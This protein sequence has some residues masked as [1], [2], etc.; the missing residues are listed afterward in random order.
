MEIEPQVFPNKF[1]SALCISCAFALSASMLT[2]C[3]DKLCFF[4]VSQLE[5]MDAASLE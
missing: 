2:F 3:Y 4:G 5:K 1:S